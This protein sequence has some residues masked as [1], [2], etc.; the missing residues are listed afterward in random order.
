M[1]LMQ[2]IEAVCMWTPR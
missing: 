1:K 2:L